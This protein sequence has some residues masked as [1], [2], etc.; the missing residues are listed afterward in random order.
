MNILFELVEKFL[1]ENGSLGNQYACC[2]L[3]DLMKVRPYNSSLKSLKELC[4]AAKEKGFEVKIT[5][6]DREHP[7][8]KELEF[9]VEGIDLAKLRANYPQNFSENYALGELADDEFQLIV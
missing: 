4:V 7:D 8:I 5:E 9:T 1:Q 2:G 3:K 6:P